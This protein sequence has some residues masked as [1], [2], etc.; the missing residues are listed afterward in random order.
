M[1]V[2]LYELLHVRHR[3]PRSTVKGACATAAFV[4]VY[5]AWTLIVALY[6]GFWVYPILAVLPAPL[7]A[8]FMAGSSGLGVFLYFAGR[9]MNDA[10][11]GKEEKAQSTPKKSDSTK[12]KG[13][14]YY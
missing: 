7:R 4:F 1:P 5:N 2:Q 12:K 13:R 14:K 9:T 8:A 10:I 6:G 11:W 3:Y